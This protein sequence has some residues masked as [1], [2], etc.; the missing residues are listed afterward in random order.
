[1]FGNY[2]WQGN[3]DQIHVFSNDATWINNS[4]IGVRIRVPIPSSSQIGQRNKAAFDLEL[5][6]NHAI[7]TREQASLTAQQLHLDHEKAL[8]LMSRKQEILELRALIYEKNLLNYQTG[9]FELTET[10]ESSNT[11]LENQQELVTAR[12]EVLATRTKINIHNEI[13]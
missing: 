9:L 13:Q 2:R 11:L 10:I 1:F 7:Q 8:A 5:A 4:A 12:V 3:N 6:K